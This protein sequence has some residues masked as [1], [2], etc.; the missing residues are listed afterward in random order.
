MASSPFV[1][2]HPRRFDVG[3]HGRIALGELQVDVF[4]GGEVV[5]QAADDAAGHVLQQFGRNVHFLLYSLVDF[6][7]VHGV[8]HVVALHGTGDVGLQP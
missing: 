5:E 1:Y 6:R 7:I 4:D 8:C 3:T 2:L